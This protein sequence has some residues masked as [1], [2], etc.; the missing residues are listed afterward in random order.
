MK[1]GS[2]AG[3]LLDLLV[4]AGCVACRAWIPGGRRAP[5]VCARC[6]SRLRVAPWPRCPRCHHPRG[7][8]RPEG[9]ECRECA[10]WP[11]ELARARWAY[12]LAPPAADLVHA[13][14]YEGWAELADFMGDAMARLE[15]PPPGPDTV[16]VPVPTTPDRL[17][18]RGYNQAELLA[19]RV[20]RAR[21]ATVAAVLARRAGGRSQTELGPHERMENVRGAFVPG[22]DAAAVAGAPVLL[23]D[24]VLTTGATAAEAARQLAVLGAREVTLVA[25]ARALPEAP[26]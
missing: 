22:A 8:G 12:V 13:L 25:F 1:P 4:P 11:P 10:A 24:D 26:R 6:R 23:V 15:L 7:G 16:V 18:R 3:D 9:D 17:R 2:W 5:L 14:K 20:A 19:R 21:G